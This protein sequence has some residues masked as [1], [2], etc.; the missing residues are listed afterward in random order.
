MK[1]IFNNKGMV[2]PLV[3]F[4]F[5]IAFLFGATSLHVT[6]SQTLFNKIDDTKKDSYEY[7]EAGYNKYMWHLNDDVSFYSSV[8]S[9]SMLETTELE[10]GYLVY[11]PEKYLNGY[12]KLRV[13][14]PSSGDRFITIESTGWN[15]SNPGIK[16][17]ILAKVRKKQFVHQVYV[18]D[19]EGS[20]IWWTTGDESI[21]P[22]HTNG[23]LRIDGRPTFFDTVSIQDSSKYITKSG[24]RPDFKVKDPEQP[25]QSGPL[26]FPSTN[27]ELSAWA[28]KDKMVFYGR[29]CIFLEGDKIKVRN[30]SDSKEQIKYYNVNDLKYKVIYVEQASGSGSLGKFDLKPGNLFISGELEG[31]LTIGAANNIYITHD[32]PT[33]WYDYNNAD[34][35]DSS[36]TPPQPPNS[37]YWNGRNNPYPEKGG[38]T[39]K[40][41]T[42]NISSDK[43]E[44]TAK[45]KDM[46]GLIANNDILVLHYGW[47]KMPDGY[48]NYWDFQ[49]RKKT[50]WFGRFIEWERSNTNKNTYDVGPRTVNIEA[51]LFS[52]GGGF[53]YED[54]NSGPRKGNIE[55][56]GNITQKERLPVGTINSTG[57]NKIYRHDPRMFYDYPPRILE[58]ANAGWE[59]HEWK[60]ID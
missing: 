5:T 33:N 16:T 46:V 25:E 28:E 53:G 50:S 11:K 4:I 34:F 55:L 1:R 43:V 30:G 17:T 48:G 13:R 10:D 42:F 22:F 58:P 35:Y 39:Y 57:Y 12:Y 59:I 49:W 26:I 54:Y 31:Q 60:V 21:G 47:P 29:T 6:S 36:T 2:M 14:K 9:D 40:N 51:A 52:V 32:D 56:W 20:N 37:Y 8:M 18:S 41:T 7:A 3:L 24:A 19:D 45:G 38:I 27:S 44:R 23:F 15:E